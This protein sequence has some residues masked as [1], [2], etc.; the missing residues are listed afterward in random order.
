MIRLIHGNCTEVLPKIIHGVP[1]TII[2]SDPPFNMG[3]HYNTYK[4]N[5]QEVEYF[6]WLSEIFTLAPAVIIHYPESLYKL[7]LTM[8]RIPEKVVSWVYNSNTR[9]QH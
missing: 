6:Q 4:D 9:K 5:M 7:A 1:D 2:V 8:G 3:Y